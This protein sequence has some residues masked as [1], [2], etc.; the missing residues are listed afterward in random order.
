MLSIAGMTRNLF[1][2]IQYIFVVEVRIRN[3]IFLK[4]MKFAKYLNHRSL[5]FIVLTLKKFTIPFDEN[6]SKFIMILLDMHTFSFYKNK[7]RV[8]VV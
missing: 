6:H 3:R 4:I 1:L 2:Y 8:N 5:H 7:I